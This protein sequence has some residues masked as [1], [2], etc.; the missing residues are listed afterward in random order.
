M[1]TTVI[2]KKDKPSSPS[3]D[4]LAEGKP[5]D[6]FTSS[7]LG[8]E[9]PL[10]DK[11]T[12]EPPKPAAAAPAPKPKP[13]AKAAPVVAP[14]APSLAEVTEAAARGVA[15]VL[16]K[17]AD[18]KKPDETQKSTLPPDEQKRINILRRM[19][20]LNP[21]S[22]AYKGISK[23]Y[24]ES[25]TKLAEYADKWEADHPGET[26]DEDAD[27]HKDF[28]KN[29]EAGL[30][31]DD[32]HYTDALADIKAN[33]VI[34]K[35]SKETDEKF[36]KIEQAENLRKAEPAIAAVRAKSAVDFFKQLGDGFEKFLNEDGS[37]NTKEAQAIAAADPVA[38]EIAINSGDLTEKLVEENFKLFNLLTPFDPKNPLHVTV[39]N[40][41]LNTEQRLL[42]QPPEKQ[43]DADGKK[44]MPGEKFWNL[45]P[46]E[47][48]NYWTLEQ[49][50]IERL[51]IKATLS[52]AKAQIKAEREKF[53]RQATA[54]G[55]QL[56]G[57]PAPVAGSKPAPVVVEDEPELKPN[58]P[59]VATGPR[60]DGKGGKVIEADPQQKFTNSFLGKST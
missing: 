24:E 51:L 4:K 8:K 59:V 43:L 17:K 5:I 54:R 60:D 57:K 11:K 40:F 23:K 47:R 19:E 37:Q 35:K 26:F 31:W 14:A 52:Q 1:E 3:A 38:T 25:L 41:V 2:E 21:D 46:E 30:D 12:D 53:E 34:S 55:I 33:E 45:K 44:F 49:S 32:E 48:K 39:N 16:E 10:V 58:T 20:E 13:K 22:E 29:L 56:N 15:S 6:V 27:E 28:K 9:T 50:H 7:F 36:T 18:E 42:N